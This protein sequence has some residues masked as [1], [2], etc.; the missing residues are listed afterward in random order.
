MF[1]SCKIINQDPLCILLRFSTIWTHLDLVGIYHKPSV[2]LIDRM[3]ETKICYPNDVTFRI[4][5]PPTSTSYEYVK[6]HNNCD[7]DISV[8]YTYQAKSSVTMTTE[9]TTEMSVSISAQW[10]LKI[11]NLLNENASFNYKWTQ[12]QI[13]TSSNEETTTIGPI[14]V[15]PGTMLKI[16]QKVG[17][18]GYWKIR[19]LDT[20][21]E[22]CDCCEKGCRRLPKPDLKNQTLLQ[23]NDY[24]VESE[25]SLLYKLIFLV[26]R[27]LSNFDN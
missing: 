19:S 1:D 12:K 13:Q 14:Y 23:Q 4:Y 10:G 15:K 3:G 7:G 5:A 8:P 24:Q 16:Y 20:K 17:N 26:V 22:T 25:N 18:V 9:M 2:W 21:T 6:G 27:Y 11:F